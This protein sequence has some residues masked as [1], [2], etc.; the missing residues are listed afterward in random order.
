MD[1]KKVALIT[2]ITGQDGSYL[3]ELLLKKG[4][5][6]YGLVRR[7]SSFNT[8][9]INHLLKDSH[10]EGVRV[11]RLYG[12]LSDTN[13]IISAFEKIKS[14]GKKLPDEIYNLGAQSHVR[15]SF[16]NPEYT[17]NVVGLGT[18]RLLDVMRLLCPKAKF[19]QASSSEMFGNAEEV[20][21]TEKTSF[22]PLSPYAC[23]KV[24]AHNVVFNYRKAYGLHASCGILFNHESERRGEIFVTRKIT[25]GLT[26][27]KLGLQDTIYLGN[28]N[29]ERDWGHAKDYVE[30]MW[31]MLQQEKP[32][33]YI[34]GTGEK[35]S[36]REFLEK[37]AE[38]LRL[39]IKSNGKQGINEEYLDEN[40][41]P[42]IKIDP[43][44]FRPSEVDV[45]QAN[46]EKT[47]K[48]LG[49]EPKIKFDELLKIMCDHDLELA[50]KE[51]YLKKRK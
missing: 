38:Y 16:D 21:Q 34:V 29:A 1:D 43:Q 19:Y 14:I 33:D 25:R 9:R 39:N 45:L 28:L 49:W 3:A 26:R 47:R 22:N 15:I 46:S 23:A 6:V 8:E 31:L 44:F 4:Y 41:N 17:S 20:P 13:S 40:G 48:L 7:S 10:E 51:A 5:E 11:T 35:H 42:I 12:D 2:G 27:I 36:V 30:A 18:Q 32:G 24:F 50:E 37:C